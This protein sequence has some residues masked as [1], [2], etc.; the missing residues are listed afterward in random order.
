MPVGRHMDLLGFP[1]ARRFRYSAYSRL[2]PAG[3]Q[4][5]PLPAGGFSSRRKGGS[6][7]RGAMADLQAN[8]VSLISE[9]S[10]KAES[11]LYKEGSELL[12]RSL[13]RVTFEKELP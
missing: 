12:D 4:A 9:F 13:D 6:H 3:R 5:G 2:A 1:I 10:D 8:L 11:R 7:I